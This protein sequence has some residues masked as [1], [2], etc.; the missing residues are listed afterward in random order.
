MATPRTARRAALVLA[1][2]LGLAFAPVPAGAEEPITAA[3]AD[4]GG[5]AGETE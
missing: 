1:G 3:E 5:S 4:A 2:A